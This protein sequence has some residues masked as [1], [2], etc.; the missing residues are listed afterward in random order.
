MTPPD[1]NAQTDHRSNPRRLLHTCTHWCFSAGG[2]WKG[3]GRL[4]LSVCH[5]LSIPALQ[6][7]I[8]R[9]LRQRRKA[10]CVR[11]PLRALFC[12]SE[13][14]PTS[15]PFTL[16]EVVITPLLLA[17]W[18]QLHTKRACEV[19][20]VVNNKT[21]GGGVG[22]QDLEGWL[23]LLRGISLKR[24]SYIAH[25]GPL[26]PTLPFNPQLNQVHLLHTIQSEQL[27]YR[28]TSPSKA[29][30]NCLSFTSS[31]K[32]FQ[33]APVMYKN[34]WLPHVQ[35]ALSLSVCKIRELEEGGRH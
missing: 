6:A 33:R 28:V 8:E 10:H 11:T 30:I 14:R 34:V 7:A 5:L 21:K 24:N 15:A 9:H 23:F 22:A 32:D 29:P 35:N 27:I 19:G 1:A 17:P 3:R 18:L 16:K 4:C 2:T 20:P 26:I 25:R 31:A 12:F 13:A